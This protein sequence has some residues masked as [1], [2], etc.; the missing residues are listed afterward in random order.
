[1]LRFNAVEEKFIALDDLILQF[2]NGAVAGRAL[3]AAYQA[4]RVV[5]DLGSGPGPTPPTPPAPTT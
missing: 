5:R 3:V 4:A 2:A 1:V